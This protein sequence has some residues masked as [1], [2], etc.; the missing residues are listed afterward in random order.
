MGAVVVKDRRHVLARE[1]G[2]G[3]GDDETRL[4]HSPVSHNHHFEVL[5]VFKIAKFSMGVYTRDVF[6]KIAHMQTGSIGL[7]TIFRTCVNPYR[8]RLYY[9]TRT[10]VSATVKQAGGGA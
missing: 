9:R 3:V 7:C 1:L 8:M 2:G 10:P 6:L 5:H 4:P